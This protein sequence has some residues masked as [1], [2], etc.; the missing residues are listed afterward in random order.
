MYTGDHSRTE[1]FPKS[2]RAGLAGKCWECRRCAYAL[3]WENTIGTSALH[4]CRYATVVSHR[5][6]GR[7]GRDFSRARGCVTNLRMGPLNS[8]YNMSDRGPRRVG[9]REMIGVIIKE[10]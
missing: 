4:L 5:P 7:I 10:D 3:P 2:R 9:E 6:V 8:N 1:G